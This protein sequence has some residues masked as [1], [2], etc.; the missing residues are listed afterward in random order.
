M[1]ILNSALTFINMSLCGLLGRHNIVR[2]LS[3]PDFIIEN[4][5]LISNSEISKGYL[6]FTDVD[7]SDKINVKSKKS[8]NDEDSF[9][10]HNVQSYRQN[11][12]RSLLLQQRRGRDCRIHSQPKN[13]PCYKRVLPAHRLNG[14]RG[15]SPR[16]QRTIVLCRRLYSGDYL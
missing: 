11:S 12:E 4:P 1:L 3:D 6:E 16:C 14:S 15:T 2:I 10:N 8:I 7:L 5:K 9:E 13:C